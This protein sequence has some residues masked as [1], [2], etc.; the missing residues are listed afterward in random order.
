[1]I[2]FSCPGL[3][4]GFYFYYFLQSGSWEY[5]L[6]GRWT[7]EPGVMRTAFLPGH[8]KMT[9]GFFFL[10]GIPRALASV[11]TLVLCALLSLSFRSQVQ[12]RQADHE[13]NHGRAGRGRAPENHGHVTEVSV[14]KRLQLRAYAGELKQY[15]DRVLAAGRGAKG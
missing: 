11:L 9:A 10:P 3:V 2:C 4:F 13:K 15:V 1:M 6:G 12:I 7:N 5:Y 14:E 8:D